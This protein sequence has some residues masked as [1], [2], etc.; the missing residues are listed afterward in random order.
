MKKIQ[1]TC[2]ICDAPISIPDD[3]QVSEVISCTD[4]KSKLVIENIS[5][6]M[7]TLAKA[8]DVEEDWGE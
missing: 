4:C 8:P 3:S 6:Q 2:P 1:G 5:G 7:A